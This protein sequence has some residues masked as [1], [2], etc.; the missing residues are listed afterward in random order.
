M[1]ELTQPALPAQ[2]DLRPRIA[3]FV[4]TRLL[5]NTTYRMLYPFL[6][7]F[8]RGL[9]ISLADLSGVLSL[10]SLLGAFAA[11][12]IAQ[13]GERR[14]RKGAMTAG[15][16]LFILG[17]G[18][19]ALFPTWPAFIAAVILAHLGN[20]T[21]LPAMQAYLGD[22]VPFRQRG[23]VMAL[24]ELSWSL[25]FILGAPLSGLLIERLGWPAVFPLLAGGGLLCWGLL[26]RWIPSD[27]PLLAARD[28]LAPQASGILA[29]LG[30][31]LP[32]PRRAPP[33]PSA[34]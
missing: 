25:A 11:P 8:A 13:L 28:T 26:L 9:G 1:S 6:P 29:G 3:L 30:K 17:C 7:V 2:A 12:F 21:F 33:W 27:R 24:T 10:R 4:V 5:I 23:Q 20:M 31:V 32:C 22:R 34:C 15:L 18:L 16:G 14:G 19:V